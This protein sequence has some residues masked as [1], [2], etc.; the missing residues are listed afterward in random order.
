MNQR[1]GNLLLIEQ[2]KEKYKC[3]CDCWNETL[4]YASNIIS[5]KSTSCWNWCI[6][7]KAH[8]VWE[9]Y[10][11]IEILSNEWVKKNNR[12]HSIVSWKCVCWNIQNYLYNSL[13]S[14]NTKSCWCMKSSLQSIHTRTHWLTNSRFKN[15]Y[16][17]M[18]SRC[19]KDL[20]NNW[21]KYYWAKWVVC[22]W[23]S[24]QSFID[25][26][27]DSYVLHINEYWNDTSID[28]VNPFWN[29]CKE[30]C[31]WATMKEQ[32]NNKRKNYI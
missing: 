23:K 16:Y 9:K 13:T 19:N 30:N 15:I 32:A 11:Y 7:K 3:I 2:Q 21:Y 5:W 22:F 27:Y 29:Y 4:Q 12:T 18:Q 14:G 26:M 8:Y 25:D 1:F 24:F 6:L 17:N 31:R 28:R 10:W 20:D